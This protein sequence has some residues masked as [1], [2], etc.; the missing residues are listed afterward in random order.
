MNKQNLKKIYFQLQIILNQRK[1]LH[2]ISKNNYLTILNLHRVSN[3]NNPF[4]PSLTTQLF[5]ELL[6]FITKEFNVITFREIEEYRNS[7][8]PNIILSF[9]DGF[10]D[11]VEYAMPLL[12]KYNISVNQNII[13]SCIESGK[14]VWD[15][16]LGDFLNQTSI[17]I[18]NQLKFPN[19]KMVLT[20]NSKAQF[21]LA[22]THYL[23]N[24]PKEK[25]EILWKQIDTV[26]QKENIE[27]T[28]M[29][30]RDEVIEISKTHE[31]GCHSY[32]HESMGIESKEFFENDFSKC[33]NYFKE[34]LN[35]PLNIYAFP[36]G[37]YQQYQLDFL[38]ESGIK[39]ILL[40][41]ENYSTYDRYIYNRF[42]FYGNSISEIKMRALGWKRKINDD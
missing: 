3:E 11:F 42:T 31:I 15:V 18:V 23:K 21:G 41:N 12:D 40:V 39:H 37:S 6:K 5:E 19:F 35:L 24:R 13:P 8:K 38:R 9:D 16:M 2:N 32:S 28:R 4:Y 26:I 22:L 30:N 20:P 7:K 36:S 14:P 27:L 34:E 25:R 29:L 1:Y 17:N 10:Y 33:Q